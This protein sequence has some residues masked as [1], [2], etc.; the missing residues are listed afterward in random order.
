V[1]Y[2][3]S[4]EMDVQRVGR[5]VAEAVKQ[6]LPDV[7]RDLRNSRGFIARGLPAPAAIALAE[8]AEAELS[9]PTLVLPDAECVA[10]APVMRIRDTTVTAE[11]IRCEAYAWDQTERVVA[12]WGEVFLIS[13]GRLEIE[14]AVEIPEE[15]DSRALGRTTPLVMEKRHEFLIDLVLFEP[16]RVLRLD[17]N[18]V[19]F[20]LTEMGRGPEDTLGPLFR[21]A[22]NLRHLA[23]GVPM[24]RGVELLA[25]GA[26]EVVWEPLTFLNKRDF[27]TY[28]S[29]LVQLLRYGRPIPA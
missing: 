24:N 13:C 14:R 3:G 2:A 10:L 9:A 23:Q 11:G 7:T 12:N 15:S 6:P 17:Q 29:W 26:S 18:T 22:F 16:W 8:K 19:A 25:A 1:L 4:D 5:L 27:E 28:T 20:S 21:C